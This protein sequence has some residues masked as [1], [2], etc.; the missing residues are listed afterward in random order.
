MYSEIFCMLFYD[1]SLYGYSGDFQYFK[2]SL[3]FLG[4]NNQNQNSKI[5]ECFSLQVRSLE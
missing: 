3:Y 5:L 2:T 1:H 4:H